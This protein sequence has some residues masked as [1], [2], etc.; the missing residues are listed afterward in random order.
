MKHLN[1][2][3][4]NQQQRTNHA[5]KVQDVSTS[6]GNTK[7]LNTTQKIV[8]GNIRKVVAFHVLSRNSKVHSHK[9]IIHNDNSRWDSTMNFKKIIVLRESH[10]ICLHFLQDEHCSR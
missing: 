3:E 9:L 2:I 1:G 5:L 8:E 10:L 4:K 6:K 7:M